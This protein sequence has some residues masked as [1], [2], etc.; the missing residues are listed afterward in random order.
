MTWLVLGLVLLAALALVIIA[1]RKRQSAPAA[2]ETWP[3]EKK[4]PVL[5]Q[6]EQVLYHR[7]VQALPECIVLGQVQLSRLLTV[8]QGHDVTR[9]NNRTSQKSVDFVVCLK[10]F[11]IVSVVE[12][13][14]STHA[15]K[16]RQTAD[17]TKDRAL[18]SADVPIIRWNVRALPDEAEI[19]AAFTT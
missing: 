18:K 9:W 14:D 8:K 7:L 2:D 6:P 13:D 3:Y 12:L 5:S 11:T 4:S 15:R 10:D 19:R 1:L 17:A 16:S